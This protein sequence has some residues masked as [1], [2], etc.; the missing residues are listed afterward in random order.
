MLYMDCNPGNP[1]ATTFNLTMAHELQHLVNFNQK[2]FVQGSPAGQDTWINE[3]LS[4]AA[5]YVYRQRGAAT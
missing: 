4:N 3:G 1:A 2:V 5:E